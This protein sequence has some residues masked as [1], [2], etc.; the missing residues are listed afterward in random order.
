MQEMFA[1]SREMTGPLLDCALQSTLMPV[2]SRQ[3]TLVVPLLSV[4]H[5]RRRFV[6][7]IFQ[8]LGSIGSAKAFVRQRRE[9]FVFCR[10]L[11]GQGFV[12]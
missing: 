7:A 11:N 2:R 1:V 12:P 6:S 9:L 3:G 8:L 10:R 4:R 5:Q